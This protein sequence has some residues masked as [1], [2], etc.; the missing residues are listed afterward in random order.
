LEIEQIRALRLANQ[1]IGSVKFKKPEEIVRYMGAMQAQMYHMAKWAVGLRLPGSTDS[2]VESA[3]NSGRIIRTHIL[4]PTWHFVH[5]ADLGWMLKLSAPR[6]HAFNAFMYRQQ[7]LDKKLL[8]KTARIICKTL[9]GGRNRTRS[10]IKT[11]LE[12][13]GIITNTVR[14]SCIMMYAELEGLICSGPRTGK[15][16]TYALFEERIKKNK[17]L[18]RDECLAELAKR[19]FRSRGPASIR[20]FAWWSGL[21]VKDTGKALDMIKTKLSTEEF[22]GNK[23]FFYEPEETINM[24]ILN[25]TFL[26]PDYDEY[27][28]SYS[29]RNILHDNNAMKELRKSKLNDFSRWIIHKGA[30]AG[31]WNPMAGKMIT[32]DMI[33]FISINKD[34]LHKAKKAYEDFQNIQD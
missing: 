31:T 3:L 16:F 7:K 12:K 26:I 14:L 20:D 4:R 13:R 27:A 30:I 33:R 1:H 28:I 21:T 9:E 24:S 34:S 15:Q 18:A 17:Q 5:P 19:Y 25:R 22:E 8:A 32:A 10:E 11:E 23:M 29:N 2:Q 6:V